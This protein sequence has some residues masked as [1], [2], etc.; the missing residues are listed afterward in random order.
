MFSRHSYVYKVA[1]SCEIQADVYRLPGDAMRPALLWL[2]GGALIFGS[3]ATLAPD[4]LERYLQAG[5]AVISADYRL[6]PEVKLPAIIE[7]LQDA[8]HWLRVQGPDRCRIDPE[9]IAVIGHS[10]GGYLALMA[11]LRGLEDLEGLSGCARA[12]QHKVERT[13]LAHLALYPDRAPQSGDDPFDDRQPQAIS[14]G[15][16]VLSPRE[17]GE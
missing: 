1:S 13:T 3:R 7:D 12:W 11:D 17:L 6:A 2:H 9:R 5:Y 4:Q 10:A 14:F 16:S 8:Y 15:T